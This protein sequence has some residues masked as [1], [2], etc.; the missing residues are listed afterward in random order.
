MIGTKLAHYEITSHLGTGGMGEVYQ[1]TDAKLGRSVAIKLLPAAFASDPDR[2]SRFRREAQLLASLNHPNIAHIYGLE[3]SG[4]T[5][6]IVMELVEGETLQARIKRGPIPV[7]EALALARQICEA[8][9]AAHEKGV[10]H[11]DLKGGNVM[12]TRDGTVKVLDF[13]LAKAYDSDSSN[14][15]HPTTSNSPTMASMAATNAGVILGTAAY[16]SP[17]QVRGR[18]VDKRTDIWAFGAVL[19]EML[20]GTSAFGDEDVSMTLSK[21]LQREPDF[22]A[23]PPATPKRVSQ[24]LRLCLRK[25]PKQRMS[26]IRDVRLALEGAFETAAPPALAPAPEPRVR[27]MGARGLTVLAAGVL[28]GALLTAAALW[29]W[30][31]R[32][33]APATPTRTSVMTPAGRRVSISGFPS[34]SLALSPDGTQLVYVGTNLEAPA[35][36]RGA[37]LQ[38]RSLAN[39]DVRDLPGTTGARQPFF[40][41]DGQWVAFFTEGELKKISLAGGTPVTLLEKINGAAISFGVWTKDNTIVFGTISSGLRQV[42]AEGGVAGDLTTLDT[43]KERFHSFP[44]LTPSSRAVLFTN[45]RSDGTLRVDGVI[46]DSGVRRVVVENAHAPQVL[47]SGHLLFQRAE[48]ILV[49]PFDEEQLTVTGPAVPLIDEVRRDSVNSPFPAA[50]L[51]VSRSGTL[52]YVPA[53][54]TTSRLGL[55]SRDG[56]FEPLGPPPANFGF[57]RVSPDGQAIAFVVSRGQD[58]EVRIYDLLRG[59]ITKLTQDEFVGGPAAWRDNRSLAVPSRRKDAF[60]IFLKNLDGSER[61]LVPVPAGGTV[62]RNLSWLPDGTKLAYTLQT[63]LL[64]DIWM[65]TMGDKPTAEP[66]LNSPASEYSPQFSPDGRWLAYESDASG[67]QE[68]YVQPYPKGERL[69]VSTSGGSGPVWRRDGKELYFMGTDAGVRK[70]VAVPVT[71]EGASLRL[72][73]PAPLFDLRVP[74]P[75]GAIEQYQGS[76]NFGAGYDVLPDGRFVMVRGADPTATREIVIVQNWFEE[77]KHLAPAK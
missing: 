8:L 35:D 10:I 65:L 12:L 40:S 68:V 77:L 49:A 29:F 24:V 46:L 50:E 54:D 6:C 19:Y 31:G 48:T 2:L 25:D 72:G 7:D 28:T 34:R 55:V 53:T 73:K 43:A 21:V 44:A 39:I 11:R 42:S 1:A 14:P 26:D 60:G 74:G 16:M 33:P 27:I 36:Q 57:P 67:R 58:S 56:A 75:A 37:H 17:E 61:Q 30:G 23:L 15:A 13:G 4:D 5:R 32:A 51:A 38:V 63:G 22:D 9:E 20:T 41:P 70:M 3:E 52:A 76:G 45:R 69:P 47:S 62:L 64:H 59:G 71:P 18:T 66:F